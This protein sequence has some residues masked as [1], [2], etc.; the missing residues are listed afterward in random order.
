MMNIHLPFNKDC[1]INFYYK[2]K[3]LIRT[4]FSRESKICLKYQRKSNKKLKTQT[5]LGILS[6]SSIPN[7]T[8]IL[9]KIAY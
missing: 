6:I 9:F 1:Q 5:V 4:F 8:A 3:Y 7:Y 2:I